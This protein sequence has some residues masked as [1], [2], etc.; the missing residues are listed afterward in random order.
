MA[1]PI[2]GLPY[3][4]VKF[5]QAGQVTD[6]DSLQAALPDSGVQDLFV[7]SHGW[8]NSEQGARSLYQ[9]LFKLLVGMLSDDRKR[10]TGLVGV[11]WPSLLFPEDGPADD[12][13]PAPT[14][15]SPD[16]T[17]VAVRSTGAEL[18]AALKDKFP[19]KSGNVE[20]IGAMLDAREPD[21]SALNT[22][23]ELATGLVTTP[24]TGGREDNGER[25]VLTVPPRE[26]FEELAA[27]PG[28]PHADTQGL[29]NPFEVA[30]RGARE[31]LRTMSYYEMKNRAGVVGKQG[32]G[33]LLGRL[34]QG[35]AG[36]RVHLM[37]HSFGAR[38]V[39]FSLAGLPDG[40]TGAASPV[41]SLLLIQGA[42][43][44]FTFSKQTPGALQA[45]ADRVDGP[46]LATFSIHDRAVGLWYPNA[47][48]LARQA[49][50][51]IEEFNFRWGGMGHDGYQQDGVVD[52]ALL[53]QGGDYGLQKGTFYRLNGNAV[54]KKSL[55]EFSEAHSDIRHPEVAWAAVSAAALGGSK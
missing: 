19:G 12:G 13:S 52:R 25:A 32:L 53:P 51:G 54:I 42:F 28:E 10:T 24:E 18:A 8:N 15:T 39:A 16:G 5:D 7:F 43:S 38:L 40:M 11:F 50:Q 36:L 6:D 26:A 48:R 22:F 4:E 17:Q 20:T 1:A 55:S 45:M 2:E 49:N 3:W 23:H 41:R 14:T 47:S 44:H 33:P 27:A 30:W 31:L 35:A 9:D 46:L 29:P 21:G 34:S 37:G